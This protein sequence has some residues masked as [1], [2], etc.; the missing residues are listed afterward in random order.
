MQHVQWEQKFARLLMQKAARVTGKKG[1][2]AEQNEPHW[3]S[4]EAWEDFL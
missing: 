3:N 1:N 2:G 4:P